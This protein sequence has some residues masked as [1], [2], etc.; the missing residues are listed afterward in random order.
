MKKTKRFLTKRE[1]RNELFSILSM[2]NGFL[3]LGHVG[4]KRQEEMIKYL[5]HQVA[6]RL[7]ELQDLIDK[8]KLEGG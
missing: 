5:P 1:L 6:I 3:D 4:G 8:S 7:M 2:L